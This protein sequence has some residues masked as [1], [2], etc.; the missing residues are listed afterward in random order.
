MGT[1]KDLME[2]EGY[3]DPNDFIENEC[4]GAGW[5]A[6]VPAICTNEGC[7]FCIDMEP[8]QDRGWCNECKTNTVASA[9]IL[10]GII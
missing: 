6:G 4:M 9:L 7:S 5:R 3:T 10:Y 8:D 2:Q 1:F